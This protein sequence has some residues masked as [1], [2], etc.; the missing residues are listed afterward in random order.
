M[1]AKDGVGQLKDGSSQLAKGATDLDEGAGKLAPRQGG[2]GSAGEM[3]QV[4]PRQRVRHGG[5]VLAPV[6]MG[7]AAKAHQRFHRDRPSHVAGLR[8]IGRAARA[9]RRVERGEADDD[10]LGQ[11]AKDRQGEGHRQ[12]R[13]LAPARAQQDGDGRLFD[14]VPGHHRQ[15]A[16]ADQARIWLVACAVVVALMALLLRNAF[17]VVV[18]G[19]AVTT[20]VC[21]PI[22][23]VALLAGPISRRL[24]GRTAIV[25]AALVGAII[26]IAGDYVGAYLVPGDNKLPVGIITGLAGAP[27]LAWLLLTSQRPPR[28]SKGRAS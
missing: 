14:H 18:I 2:G 3:G 22:S 16:R 23:F 8:Q 19:V 12:H 26:T 27:V 6:G 21:G 25:A 10:R 5:G 28:R 24:M 11:V 20:S 13:R 7:A 1:L 15:H 4:H 17:G 9:R